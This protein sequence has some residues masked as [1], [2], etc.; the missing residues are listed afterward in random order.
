[1]EF[2]NVIVARADH[3]LAGSPPPLPLSALA[4]EPWV[5]GET[6]SPLR[7]ELERRAHE[8][9]IVLRVVLE[10]M[11]VDTRI[12]AVLAGVGLAGLSAMSVVPLVAAGKLAVLP[13][14]GFPVRFTWHLLR[15]PGYLPEPAARLRAHLLE[16]RDLMDATPGRL[17]A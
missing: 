13:V 10:S 11:G 16:R 17:A 14:Q 7:A 15:R 4:T 5:F 3:P 12:R 6:A 9:G 1:M 8:A 2:D